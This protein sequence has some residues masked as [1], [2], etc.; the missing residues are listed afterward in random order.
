MNLKQIFSISVAVYII[1][2]F[3][4]MYRNENLLD[5]FFAI[6]NKYEHEYMKVY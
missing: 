4:F 3:I 1:V 5:L 2:Q 6:I